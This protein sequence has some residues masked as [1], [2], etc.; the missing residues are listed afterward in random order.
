M[1]QETIEDTIQ[2]KGLNAPRVKPEDIDAAI[3]SKFFINAWEAAMAMPSTVY[4]L[5]IPDELK[6]LTICVLVLKNGFTVV[7]KSACASVANY[8]REVGEKVA[9]ED[10]KKQLWPLLGY[11][12]RERLAEMDAKKD[13]GHGG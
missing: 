8:D 4:P 11:A 9:L 2:R 7:G 6:L 13:V 12:L 10:A 1:G 5:P 3:A